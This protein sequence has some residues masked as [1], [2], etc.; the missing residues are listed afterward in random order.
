ML[1]RLFGVFLNKK[2]DAYKQI[3]SLDGLRG[4][5]VLLVLVSHLSNA[6]LPLFPALSFSGVGKVGVWLFF[7][8]SSFLLTLQ[9][10]DKK[11]ESLL[12]AKVWL[13]Y[14]TRRF[15]R[16]YPL[17]TVV[18]LVSWAFSG[19]GYFGSG[20]FAM[21]GLKDVVSRLTLQTAKGVE[22]SILVEFRYYL[23]LPVMVL[24]IAY[25][26]RRNLLYVTLTTIAVVIIADLSRPPIDLFSLRPYLSI[27]ILGSFTAYLYW[28]FRQKA[29]KLSFKTKWMFEILAVFIA[30]IIFSLTPSIYSMLTGKIVPLDYWHSDL[31]L[32][33]VLWSL[34]IFSYMNGIGYIESLL[35]QGYLRVIGIVSF[36]L[37]LWH[38]PVIEYVK[39]NYHAHSSIQA[40]LALSI[41]LAISCFTYIIVERP[42]QKIKLSGVGKA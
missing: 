6:G 12:S 36:G 22:W 42:F 13:N 14:F 29:F 41:A 18:M 35:S 38:P 3:D 20:Y 10:L 27:F 24:L 39:Q 33:A 28:L 26:L 1:T 11:E 17:F 23:A 34:F 5:A 31:T 21:D 37:Y 19:S 7:I 30:I 8:L 40:C 2:P 9:F 4:V 25:P 32:F 15:F 16:I